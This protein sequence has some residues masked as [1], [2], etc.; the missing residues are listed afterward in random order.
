MQRLVTD[1]Q[2]DSAQFAHSLQVESR[3]PIEIARRLFLLAGIVVAVA[4]YF[5]TQFEPYVMVSRATSDE[6]ARAEG[7][8]EP[9]A[10]RPGALLDRRVTRKGDGGRLTVSGPEWE[11]F[12]AGVSKTFAE[13]YPIPGW[14]HR[15]LKRDLDGARKDNEQRGRMTAADRAEEQDRIRRL[16]AQYHTDVTFRGSFRQLYFLAGEQP[17]SSVIAQWSVGTRYVLQRA[18]MPEPKLSVVY[19]SAYQLHGFSDV[20]TLPQ[21]FSF[22]HRHLAH[23][24]ALIGLALYIILPWGRRE[25]DV[26][27]YARWRVILGD[28][29]AGLLMFGCFFAMPFAIIGGTVETVTT[30]L[31][32]ALVF[33]LIAAL[34]FVAVYWTTWSAAYR[35]AI[36]PEGLIIAALSRARAISY[37]AIRTVQPVR[38]RPPKWLIVLLWVAALLGRRPGGVGQALILGASQSNGLRLDLADGTRAYVWYSDQM[39][40]TSIPHFER[41]GQALRREPIRWADTPVEMRA[42]FPPTH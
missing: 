28:V 32:F 1:G 9:E 16:K 30:F 24:P 21:A 15:I 35:L 37:D 39:G 23:W 13:N 26:L 14:E 12:F 7:R 20:I 42:I 10:R 18:E 34:G 41:L 33:W 38:I 3:G 36:R 40:S 17:F 29:A 4:L 31:L 11:Q 27:A 22:P 2:R 25:P 8:P 6:I 19:L 5:W